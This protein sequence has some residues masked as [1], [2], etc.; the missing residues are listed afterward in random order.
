MPLYSWL[1]DKKQ[2]V[3]M[4]K[5]LNNKLKNYAVIPIRER[6]MVLTGSGEDNVIQ[7]NKPVQMFNTLNGPR[8]VHEGEGLVNNP[9]GSITVIPQSRLSALEKEKNIPGYKEGGILNPTDDTPKPQPQPFD[10]SKISIPGSNP[11]S[12]NQMTNYYNKNN[13]VISQPAGRTTPT[14]FQIRPEANSPFDPSKISVPGSTTES[15]NQMYNFANSNIP[16]NNNIGSDNKV[17]NNVTPNPTPFSIENKPISVP[18]NVAQNTVNPVT[19]EIRPVDELGIAP[20]AIR[21][22]PSI[23][24]L[25]GSIRPQEQAVPSTPQS[26]ETTARTTGIQGLIDLATKGSP[27]TQAANQKYLDDLKAT[28]YTQGRVAGQQAA[29]QGLNQDQIRAQQALSG[30]SQ[31]SALSQASSAAALTE[32]QQREAAMGALASQGFAGQQFEQDKMRYGQEFAENKRRFDQQFEQ[33]KKQYG[34]SQTWNQ[35]TAALT[36]GDYN[37]ASSLYKQITGKDLDVSTLRQAASIAKTNAMN[38]TI[39]KYAATPGMTAESSINKMIADGQATE[40]DRPILEKLF[41]GD[42]I[43]GNSLAMLRDQV[44]DPTVLTDQD[45][46]SWA[47]MSGDSTLT[48]MTPEQLRSSFFT[49]NVISLLDPNAALGGINNGST[50]VIKPEEIKPEEISAN[51][52]EILNYQNGVNPVQALV[53][54]KDPNSESHVYYQGL[55]D[56]AKDIVTDDKTNPNNSYD[57]FFKQLPPPGNFFKIENTLFKLDGEGRGAKSITKYLTDVN[58]GKR[59]ILE[60]RGGAISVKD[61]SNDKFIGTFDMKTGTIF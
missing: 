44:M 42:K 11:E 45:L 52:T 50:E 40:T 18:N 55:F 39:A 26:L 53:G 49:K 29:Q 1:D 35:Y 28:M 2:Q 61:F 19:G 33:D 30:I 51:N 43:A 17:L 20:N 25:V 59:Y 31:G 6:Y 58:T 37:T 5:E 10:P 9:N 23:S 36:A 15:I 14:P 24:P 47:K 13:N 7:P 8:M 57:V 3:R 32:A 12:I 60:V 48:N 21:T 38:T 56:K 41:S 27:A 22:E 34:D 16:T 54:S 4:Q 46:Q